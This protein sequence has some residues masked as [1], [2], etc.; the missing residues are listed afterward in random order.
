V[1]C[2]NIAKV[3]FITYATLLYL[4]LAKLWIYYQN[5]GEIKMHVFCYDNATRCTLSFH[6]IF[7]LR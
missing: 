6:T 7:L 3:A 2:N 5:F 1:R 4:E